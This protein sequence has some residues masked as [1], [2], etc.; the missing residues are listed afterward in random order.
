MS[1][2]QRWSARPSAAE[3]TTPGRPDP[4]TG[5]AHG[6]YMRA[7]SAGGMPAGCLRRRRDNPAAG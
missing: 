3:A 4:I 5:R 6:E 7:L 1:R 2:S